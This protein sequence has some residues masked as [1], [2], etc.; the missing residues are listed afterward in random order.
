MNTLQAQLDRLRD[1]AHVVR[2]P[3]G[4]GEMVWRSWGSG[5]PLVLF[6]GGGGS[7]EHWVRNI[8]FLAQ[9]RQVWTA[10]F[11]GFGDS[12]DAPEPI[13]AHS[14]AAATA[15]GLDLLFPLPQRVDIAGFSFG[16][17]IGTVIAAKRPGRVGQ[18]ILVGAAS[19]GIVRSHERLQSWR[20]AG[21][22]AERREIHRRNLHILMLR[23]DSRDDEALEL[24]MRN[25]EN[26]RFR[27]QRVAHSNLV[28]DLL[29][30]VDVSRLDAIYG[31]LDATGNADMA[32]VEGVLRARQPGLRFISIPETAHWVQY[33]ATDP[34][35]EALLSLLES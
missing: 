19:L 25:V 26:T 31:S 8:E 27:S 23:S 3:C 18:L 7:W 5:K 4:Q 16:G 12:A 2:T 32:Q 20:K 28:R 1:T 35:H 11:P 17:M 24:H 33:E 34:F 9:H 22:T 14:I 6:H 10:D 15:D 13:D 29:E 30:S 21:E